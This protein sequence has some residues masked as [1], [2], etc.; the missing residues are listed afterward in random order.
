MESSG[1]NPGGFLVEVTIHEV[2]IAENILEIVE[3]VAKQHQLERIEKVVLEIGQFSGVEPDLL[4]FAF[5]VIVDNTLLQNTEIE[6]LTPPLV[7]YCRSCETE[8][9][10]EMEDLRCPVCLGEEFDVRQGK[11]M[12]VRSIV[13]V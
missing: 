6:I 3:E 13:G 10:G 12:L 8:Y 1:R 9:L 4:R 11:E 2:S 5:Q 7:L